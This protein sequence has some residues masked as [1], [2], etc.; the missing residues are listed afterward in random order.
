MLNFLSKLFSGNGDKQPAKPDIAAT[1]YDGFTI[2]PCPQ[3]DSAGWSTEAIITKQVDG[4]VKSHRFIRADKSG[5]Q[6]GAVTLILNKS[7]MTIDQLGNNI[8]N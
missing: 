7:R 1:E 6:D 2:Q 3:K 5:D 4:E 8:F